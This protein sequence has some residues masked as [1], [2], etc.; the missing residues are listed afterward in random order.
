MNAL[1][2]AEGNE[3]SVWK[4]IAACTGV[5]TAR[6]SFFKACN[7]IVAISYLLEHVKDW[8]PLSSGKSKL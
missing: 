1:Y 6:V 4:R 5:E 8:A 2:N 7:F 3:S